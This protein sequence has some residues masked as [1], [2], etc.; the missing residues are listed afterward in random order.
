[1]KEKR[2]EIFWTDSMLYTEGS[3]SVRLE[4]LLLTH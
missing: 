1:M 3:D 4:P 2:K